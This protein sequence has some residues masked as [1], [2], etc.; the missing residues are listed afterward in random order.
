MPPTFAGPHHC[1]GTAR[2][3]SDEV[4]AEIR[5]AAARQGGALTLQ[6]IEAV[7]TAYDQ[8]A[9]QRFN[10][11]QCIFNI[12]MCATATEPVPMAF[13]ETDLVAKF[14]CAHTSGIA[15]AVF[16]N[17]F[18]RPDRAWIGQ[19]YRALARFVVQRF[20][21][22]FPLRAIA[23]YIEAGTQKGQALTVGE[24]V[25]SAQG[26]EA[27]H[28]CL[29]RIMAEP[30]TPQ[31]AAELCAAVEAAEV[32]P[33][34][35]KPAMTIDEAERFLTLLRH[36][37]LVRTLTMT[38]GRDDGAEDDLDLIEDVRNLAFRDLS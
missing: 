29:L 20:D 26:R 1:L 4:F 38:T 10:A 21:P 32:P 15:W 33:G 5:E 14:L 35:P 37:K 3:V 16:E 31:I 19:F 36:A 18:E 25:Q 6:Q 8:A 34:A 13:D 30:I 2:R 12:C 22:G 7:K 23:V 27:V 17:R 9:P 28:E 11:I 24:L